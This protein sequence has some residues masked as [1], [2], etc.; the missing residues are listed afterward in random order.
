MEEYRKAT[1]VYHGR[2]LPS[3][4]LPAEPADIGNETLEAMNRDGIMIALAPVRSAR[5]R[6]LGFQPAFNLAIHSINR[7]AYAPEPVEL[8]IAHHEDIGGINRIYEGVMPFRDHMLR[9]EADWEYISGLASQHGGGLM[10]L[11]GENG[12]DGYA[13]VAKG[14]DGIVARELFAMDEQTYGKTCAGVLDSFGVRTATMFTPACP[15]DR[16]VYG[17]VRIV[18]AEGMLRI[19][20]GYRTEMDFEIE[21]RDP[22]AE[23]NNGTYSVKGETVVKKPSS[24]EGMELDMASFAGIL[25][26]AGPMPYLNLLD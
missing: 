20:A 19:A 24:G 5:V 10:V 18:D 8:V 26:G 6:E 12:V 22:Y 17:A 14:R 11:R 9:S 13:V 4:Y 25:F 1:F 15:H 16:D 3:A 23:W 2:K 7:P 21:V